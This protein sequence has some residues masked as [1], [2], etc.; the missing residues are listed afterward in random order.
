MD[1]RFDV[2]A[3]GSLLGVKGY[4]KSEMDM[5]EGQDSIPVGYENV[6]EMYPLDFEEF[7]WA[8]GINEKVI[9]T[10]KSCFENETVVP[11][12]IHKVMMELL[13]RYVIVGGLPDVVNTFLETKNIEQTYH[14][15]RSLIAEY[16][17]DMVKYAADEDKSRIREC[18]ESIPKQLAKDNKKFQY[19]VVRKG[20]RSAQYIGSIQWLEDAG[21]AKRCYNTKITELPLEGNAVSDCFKLYTT[22]IGLLVSM[23]DYGTQADILKGNFTSIYILRI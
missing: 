4:G 10:V 19:S 2:I 12:G 22:D 1:G 16:E 15:Q 6:V 5:E 7:L 13:Y 18:F 9:A 11:Y 21:I 23:L 17:D 8:N 14:V 20:A 3:T